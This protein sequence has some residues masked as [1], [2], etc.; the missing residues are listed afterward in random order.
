MMVQ[1]VYAIEDW[2]FDLDGPSVLESS[3]GCVITVV[4]PLPTRYQPPTLP[5][6]PSR[7]HHVSLIAIGSRVRSLYVV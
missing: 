3:L 1:P 2:G 5:H 6:N 7:S 4:T